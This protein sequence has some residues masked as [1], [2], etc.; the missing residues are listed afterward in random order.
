MKVP[1]TT[2]EMVEEYMTFPWVQAPDPKCAHAPFERRSRECGPFTWITGFG[3]CPD[4]KGEWSPF[5]RESHPN[6]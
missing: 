6:P 2:A 5:D 4:C 1:T 3:W